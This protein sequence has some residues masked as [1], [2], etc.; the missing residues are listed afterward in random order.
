MILRLGKLLLLSAIASIFLSCEVPRVGAPHHVIGS[1][2]NPEKPKSEKPDHESK[3]CEKE[4]NEDVCQQARANWK[5]LT[6]YRENEWPYNGR[7]RNDAAA[8]EHPPLVCVA[9]SGGGIRSAAFSIGVLKGL[10]QKKV[11]GSAYK[12][13]DYVDVLSGTSGGSYALSWYYMQ[14][15]PNGAP[16]HDL[17][18][19]EGRGQKYLQQHAS[20]VTAPHYVASGFSNV[21]LLSPLNLVLNGIWGTHTNTSL[22]HHIYR[23]DIKDTFHAG[24]SATLDELNKEIVKQALPYFVVT[25]TSRIDESQLHHDS[26]LRNTVFEFTPL[27]IGNDGLGYM[28]SRD[29]SLRDIDD[30]IS[31]AGAAP[32]SSQ[33]ISG[34]AQRFLA[35]FLNVDYGR[36]IRNYNDTRSFPR[37]FLTKLAPFPIYFFTESYN[38]DMRGSEIYLSDGGHQENLGVYPLIRRQCQNIVIVDGEY[39]PN[40]EFGSYFKVKH[41]V[42]EEM[43]VTMELTP[44]QFCGNHMPGYECRENHIDLIETKLIQN[45]ELP[46]TRGEADTRREGIPYACCFSGHHPITEGRIKYFPILQPSPDGDRPNGHVNWRELKIIYIKLSIDNELFRGWET[47]SESSKAKV[48]DWVGAEAAVYYGKSLRDACD[49]RY[50]NQ[51]NF[52]QFSTSHQSFTAKQFEAYVDLGATMVKN[53]LDAQSDSDRGALLLKAK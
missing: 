18:D 42:E 26:L 43:R 4:E 37:F 6:W 35:S 24:H 17:F 33:V 47:L 46:G 23:W 53:H 38:R 1:T 40:Y 51:C 30:V 21:V 49:V 39:D 45:F 25:T 5:E 22:A 28:N 11:T 10:F 29:A 44:T 16:D 41:L 34:S 12:L 7:R 8:R 31:V 14:K 2:L 48:K 20:F 19:S 9:L 15:L 50:G 3:F 52:P 27:R 13:L 36:Y 32:D